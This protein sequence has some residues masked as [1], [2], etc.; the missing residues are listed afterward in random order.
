MRHG[1]DALL[2]KVYPVQLC[3]FGADGAV[4]K[5]YK[6][7][8]QHCATE[9]YHYLSNT[10]LAVIESSRGPGLAALSG[11]GTEQ[12]AVSCAG[13]AHLRPP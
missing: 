1:V 11:G 12:S 8:A 3:H 9:K 10:A 2:V 6:F 7:I 5:T 4:A 13:T